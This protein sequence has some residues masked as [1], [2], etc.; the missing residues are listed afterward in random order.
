[1]VDKQH[2]ELTVTKQCELLELNRSTLYYKPRDIDRSDEYQIKWIIDEIY[3]RDSSLGYRRMTKLL[4]RDYNININK[5][6]TRRYM[7]DMGISGI[8]PGPN[9][10]KR[11]HAKHV[12][13]Y[14]LRGLDINRANQ[15]WSIDITYLRMPRGHMYLA[16]IIDWHSRYIIA[17]E[18]SNTMDKSFI[19]DLV[20]KAIMLHGKPEIFNSDQ[21]GCTHEQQTCLRPVAHSSLVERT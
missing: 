16:A 11:L 13:P 20:N 17:Y 1:M 21:V 18:I 9:L 14:L 8:C 10:S 4:R 7:R 3:T 15:V 6:R 5:K 2:K 19:I 12:H